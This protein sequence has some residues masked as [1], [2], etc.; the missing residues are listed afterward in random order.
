MTRVVHSERERI[1]DLALT[2]RTFTEVSEAE[3]CLRV[4]MASHPEDRSIADAGEPLALR[5]MGLE[6]D[7]LQSE[8]AA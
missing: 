1:I 7:I 2:A 3:R 8:Q 6:E 5:R 4:Y